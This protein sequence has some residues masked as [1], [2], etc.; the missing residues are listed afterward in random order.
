MQLIGNRQ[1]EENPISSL[2]SVIYELYSP[3]D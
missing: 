3:D 1:D 2:L